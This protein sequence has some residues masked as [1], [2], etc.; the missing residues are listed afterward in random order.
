MAKDRAVKSMIAA[1]NAINNI[2]QNQNKLL[3]LRLEGDQKFRNSFMLNMLKGRQAVEQKKELM[4]YELEL[5]RQKSGITSPVQES[6]I[7]VNE[8]R[9]GFYKG[10]GKQP[11][12]REQILGKIQKG[13][14]LLP[15]ELQLYNETIKK[16]KGGGGLSDILNEEDETQPTGQTAIK[17]NPELDDLFKD[18]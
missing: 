11:N 3:M 15:G 4:P 18:L 9:E 14:E 12:V 5:H 8:A 16:Q 1:M 10:G 6:Q 7:K 17:A 13:E 2:Q